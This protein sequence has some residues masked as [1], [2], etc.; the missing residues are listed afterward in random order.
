M[1]EYYQNIYSSIITSGQSDYMQYD[2]NG[3]YKHA[4]TIALVTPC[5]ELTTQNSHG[6]SSKGD[7]FYHA[8][9]V[10]KLSVIEY[11]KNENNYDSTLEIAEKCVCL[12][13]G[14]LVMEESCYPM[15]KG[16]TY[17][18]FLTKS[19]YGYPLAMSANNGKFDLT[20]LSLNT[21]QQV[22]IAALYRLG[23]I[24]SDCLQ[25]NIAD[26]E[27]MLE[28]K[29]LYGVNDAGYSSLDSKT[30]WKSMTLYTDYTDRDYRIKAYAA[31]SENGNMYKL[32]S[33]IF[34]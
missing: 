7:K 4:H 20:L 11:Y 28:A 14:S 22:M 31:N 23:L 2:F 30:A 1:S 33:Y 25:D 17:L 10:R 9:S 34:A 29:P 27:S 12:D 16:H 8:Y 21:Y 13:N 32:G 18:V 26:I 19:G 3:L 15:Q 24:S 5:D 6:I